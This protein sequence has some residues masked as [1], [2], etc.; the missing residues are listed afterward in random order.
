[1]I[2]IIYNIISCFGNEKNKYDKN[3]GIK[4]SLAWIGT[5]CCYF[6]RGHEKQKNKKNK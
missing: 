1:M 5:A 3:E 6:A 4:K 2:V